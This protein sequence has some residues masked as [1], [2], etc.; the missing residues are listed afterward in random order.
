VLTQEPGPAGAG[1][2]TGRPRRPVVLPAGARAASDQGASCV[3]R[4]VDRVA[5]ELTVGPP[6]RAVVPTGGDVP[7]DREAPEEHLAI[8]ARA[9]GPVAEPITVRVA[10]ALH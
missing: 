2:A 4:V 3:S 8:E 9:E 10:P 6:V 7:R 1:N 5:D